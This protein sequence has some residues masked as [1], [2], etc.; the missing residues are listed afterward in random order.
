MQTRVMKVEGWRCY[1]WADIMMGQEC[2]MQT[3]GIESYYCYLWAER[4][5]GVEGKKDAVVGGEAEWVKVRVGGRKVN[6]GFLTQEE[7]E[8]CSKS[9]K[10]FDIV[11]LTPRL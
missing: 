2:E 8:V 11:Y 1:Y 7:N 9:F 6:E 4:E 3:K 10:L 5:K